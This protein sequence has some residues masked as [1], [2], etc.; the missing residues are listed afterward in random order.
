MNSALL[1]IWRENGAYLRFGDAKNGFLSGI[2]ATMLYSYLKYIL[3]VDEFSWHS[4]NQ[5]LVGS[6]F[7]ITVYTTILCFFVA[8]FLSTVSIVPT[9]SKSSFRTRATLSLAS[10]FSVVG[11][12]QDRRVV[13]FLDI[14]AFDTV[15]DYREC[16]RAA[17]DSADIESTGNQE[18]LEQIWIVAR[19]AS[20]KHFTFLISMSLI[21]I[22]SISAII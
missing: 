6:Q 2:S 4:I 12:A 5:I 18:L 10:F 17:I 19:I 1:N 11:P 7:R 20:S 14:A 15:D 3:I 13:Y 9:L 21:I 22:G 8:A 16:V